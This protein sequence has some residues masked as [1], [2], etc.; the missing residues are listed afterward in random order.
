MS[1]APHLRKGD[2]DAVNLRTVISEAL[3]T[4]GRQGHRRNSGQCRFMTPSYLSHFPPPWHRN[5]SIKALGVGQPLALAPAD[6]TRRPRTMTRT[7]KE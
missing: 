2:A 5:E 6:E 3:M 7:V 1:R 4:A